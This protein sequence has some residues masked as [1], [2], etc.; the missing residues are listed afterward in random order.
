M[1]VS[2]LAR[3]VPPGVSVRRFAAGARH[4][5]RRPPEQAGGPRHE[6][7]ARGPE[8]R[9]SE[10]LPCPFQASGGIRTVQSRASGLQSA[11]QGIPSGP[12]RLVLSQTNKK[13]ER[14]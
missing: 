13:D 1:L 8:T 5:E 2:P 6:A 10:S 4:R 3:L 11:T 9:G 7:D 12:K 14:Y